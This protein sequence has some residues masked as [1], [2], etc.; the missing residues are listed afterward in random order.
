MKITCPN[1]AT[2]YVLPDD[3]IGA[4]GRDVRCTRCGTSWFAQGSNFAGVDVDAAVAAIDEA[5]EDWGLDPEITAPDEDGFEPAEMP[6]GMVHDGL[7]DD[8]APPE[9]AGTDPVDDRVPAETRDIES[10]ARPRRVRV[11][12]VRR[13]IKNTAY[14]MAVAAFKLRRYAG[15]AVFFLAVAAI[16]ALAVKRDQVVRL[17]PDLGSLYRVVGLDVNLRGLEFH[18]VKT[19]RDFEDGDVVLVVEGLIANISDSDRTVPKIRFGLRGDQDEEIYAWALDPVKQTLPAGETIA[20]RSRFTAPPARARRV[21]V[22]FTDTL[23]GKTAS[24]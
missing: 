16:A 14:L 7:D 4:D 23:M 22:R 21:Q 15:V 19:S 8:G 2:S 10:I 1:C 17:V 18:D 9:L 24:R 20:F 6:A 12:Q 11:R 13:R 3:A 5:A